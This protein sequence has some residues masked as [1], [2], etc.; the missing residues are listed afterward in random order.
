MKYFIKR[1]LLLLGPILALLVGNISLSF[2]STP[3]EWV[4]V[5]EDPRPA[6]LQGWQ[7]SGYTQSGNYAGSLELKRLGNRFAKRYG[8]ELKQQWFIESLSVYCLIVEIKQNPEE[9]L[10]RLNRD[11]KVKWVQTSNNF[12]PLQDKTSKRAVDEANNLSTHANKEEIDRP[13]I[14]SE[15][16]QESQKAGPRSTLLNLPKWVDGSGVEIAI[17]DSAVDKQH[18]DLQSAVRSSVD[19][20]LAGGEQ[21]LIGES[22]G[23]AIA[24]VLVAQPRGQIGIA[25]IAPAASLSAFRGCWQEHDGNTKCNTLSLARALDAVSKSKPTLLNLSLS[26]PKDRLLDNLIEKIIENHTIV[27]AAFDPQRPNSQRFPTRRNGVL[28]VRAET[29]DQEYQNEFTAPGGRLVTSPGNRYD[30]VSGHSIA[31]AYTSGVLALLA[32]AWRGDSQ[33]R[34]AMELSETSD[35]KTQLLYQ[36]TDQ[37]LDRVIELATREI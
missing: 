30:Y 14:E 25:G 7:A 37:L 4:V 23:T 19:F 34:L 33:K 2:A 22:H 13:K 11:D 8:L 35:N 24:G 5:L 9:T 3:E 26:G 15:S 10:A 21:N 12:T 16:S 32:Q 36:H 28:I 29:M 1:A 18:M 6:R 20:V 27:V 31:T 17:V